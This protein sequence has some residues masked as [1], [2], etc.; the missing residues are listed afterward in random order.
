MRIAV[1][2]GKG[3]GGKTTISMGLA[4]ALAMEGGRV[5]LLDMDPQASV[6]AWAAERDAPPP[7]AVKPCLPRAGAT[8]AELEALMVGHDHVVLDTPP[9][10]ETTTMRWAYVLADV[11]LLPVRASSLDALG[12]TSAVE[13]WAQARA[14]GALPPG[15]RIAFVPSQRPTRWLGLVTSFDE[16]WLRPYGLPILSGTTFQAG[17]V[18]A[19]TRALTV[20]EDNKRG[21]PAAE[22]RRLLAELKG[23]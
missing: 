22:I 18:Y 14:A 8:Q 19:A 3:G 20:F 15:Q 6:V 23:L 5:L 9:R 11:V 4:H 16:A 13:V 17:Y 10:A 2:G 7:F 21:K 1:C 12:T